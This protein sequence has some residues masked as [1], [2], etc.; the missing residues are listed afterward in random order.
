[1]CVALDSPVIDTARLRL[2]VPRPADAERVAEL[3]SD[4]DIPRMTTRMPWP[5]GLADA[6]AFVGRANSQDR[7]LENT[8]LIETEGDGPIDFCQVANWVGEWRKYGLIAG[9]G[10]HPACTERSGGRTGKPPRSPSGAAQRRR[11]P[12]PC[13]RG[14]EQA[15]HY[16]IK[17]AALPPHI[18]TGT[19][20]DLVG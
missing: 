7:D 6:V 13:A 8:F 20:L 11:R 5:Y 17:T 2:R 16:T 9:E 12:G 4:A 19:A 15:P 10:D 18:L 3:C 14:P 1:M